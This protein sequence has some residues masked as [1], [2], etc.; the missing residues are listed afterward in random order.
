MKSTDILT[1]VADALGTD[2][3]RKYYVY[4]LCERNGEQLIP[5]YI[6]KGVGNRMWNHEGDAEIA[7]EEY[8]EKYKSD[9][10]KEYGNEISTETLE[11]VSA[12]F[13]ESFKNEN[14]Q[15][16]AKIN[17]L[18]ENGR[19]ERIIVKWGLTENEAFMAEST[20]INLL[21][22]MNSELTNKVGGHASIPEKSVCQHSKAMTDDEFFVNYAREQLDYRKMGNCV[23]VNINQF[24]TLYCNTE[25]TD[26][27]SQVCDV[28]RA[29]W[30]FDT[31]KHKHDYLISIFNK[32]ICGVFRITGVY[33]I[34]DVK[35]DRDISL[36]PA[37]PA[38]ARAK[39]IAALNYIKE[40]QDLRKTNEER[41]IR[42]CA[43]VLGRT[44]AETKAWLNCKFFTC[45]DVSEALV[46]ELKG[47][48]IGGRFHKEGQPTD[49]VF[50]PR[51]SGICPPCEVPTDFIREGDNT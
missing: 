3:K 41:F 8:I 50:L 2:E 25:S 47:R 29:C 1:A 17:E 10:K 11:E 19:L 34:K 18:K 7:L 26:Y 20:L 43:E 28:S 16:I 14:Q 31:K 48:R 40:H 5:F 45:T 37:F 46:S 39:E 32:R 12:R 38:P 24:H 15:K 23:F 6:G 35:D 30:H 42:E 27:K 9:Y 36:Y 4:A 21:D 44:E 13:R 49:S 51:S 33:S 22:C